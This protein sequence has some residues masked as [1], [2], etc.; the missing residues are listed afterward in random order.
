MNSYNSCIAKCLLPLI[1]VSIVFYTG[2]SQRNNISGPIVFTHNSVV[3]KDI[4]CKDGMRIEKDVEVIIRKGV[5]ITFQSYKANII[6]NGR[7]VLEGSASQP[8]RIVDCTGIQQLTR[9]GT[10]VLR[11]AYILLV[12]RALEGRNDFINEYACPYPDLIQQDKVDIQDSR[13]EYHYSSKRTSGG[14][15]IRSLVSAGEMD[16]ARTEFYEEEIIHDDNKYWYV[17]SAFYDYHSIFL[18]GVG[19]VSNIKAYNIKAEYLA[20][21]YLTVSESMF[22]ECSFASRG[23]P[24]LGI[25]INV[26]LEEC[27]FV[28][29]QIRLQC[30]YMVK[31]IYDSCSIY[32]ESIGNEYANFIEC[33]FVET[34]IYGGNEI[35]LSTCKSVMLHCVYIDCVADK[36]VYSVMIFPI[37]YICYDNCSADVSGLTNVAICRVRDTPWEYRIY[38]DCASNDTISGNYSRFVTWRIAEIRRMAEK[39]IACENPI[40][41]AILSRYRSYKNNVNT[42]RYIVINGVSE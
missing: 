33:L 22:S 25:N 40:V 42:D 13:I 26:Y 24:V 4:V 21:R 36:N 15:P 20:T 37:I 16:V 38:V 8:S 23:L 31:C 14:H 2:C 5:T 35:D 17:Y 1:T 34:Q 12:D 19:K 18:S 29:T 10:L 9:S 7:L 3:T 27:Q 30:A 32:L 6:N 28:S 41:N 39:V 11:N